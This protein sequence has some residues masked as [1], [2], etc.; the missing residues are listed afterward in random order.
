MSPTILVPLDG[1]AFG[2]FALAPALELARRRD[3]RLVLV[4][5]QDP[6]PAFAFGE[7]HADPRAWRERY[8]EGVAERLASETEVDVE[9]RL[10]VGPVEREL[11]GVIEEVEPDLVVLSTHGRGPLSRFWIGSVADH[12]VRHAPR[13]VLL[14]RPDDDEEPD[15]FRESRFRSILVPLDESPEAEAVLP[16]V[17]SLI[18]EEGVRFHLLHVVHFPTELVSAYPPDTVKLNEEI[19]EEGYEEAK[20]YLDRIAE[21]LRDEGLV[22]ETEVRVEVH[23]ATGVI[24]AAE[25]GG[26]DMVAM[27]TRGRG[28]LERTILG[29]VTDK[30]IRAL[31]R[32]VLTL[33]SAASPR[34]KEVGTGKEEREEER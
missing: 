10:Q 15:P 18:G 3:A 34:T 11:I 7:W 4:S 2:E 22:V 20:V 28:G 8:I 21:E 1:S 16:A 29:S 25:E 19:V 26:V 33:R 24:R 17:R 32:P 31:D 6:V 23:P 13:P 9:T 5:V 27:A 14:V 12:L 30:V